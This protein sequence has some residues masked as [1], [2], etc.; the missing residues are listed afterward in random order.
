MT[1]RPRIDHTEQGEVLVVPVRVNVNLKSVT[2]EELTERRK[3]LHMA[4]A[5]NLQEELSYEA[6][7]AIEQFLATA[8][9]RSR[10]VAEVV[11]GQAD[12]DPDGYTV[13]FSKD[14]AAGLPY[15]P[16]ASGTLYFEVEV[17]KPK[18]GVWNRRSMVCLGVAGSC[19]MQ[20]AKPKAGILM[21]TDRASWA[22]FSTSD[23]DEIGTF[24]AHDF[25][26]HRD[27]MPSSWGRQ[28]QPGDVAGVLC[29]LDRGAL[30]ISVNGSF[31]PP[32]GEVFGSGVRP[33]RAVG[34]GLFPVF[35]GEGV[36]LGY[37]SGADPAGRPLR[38]AP[39]EAACGGSGAA[40][41]APDAEGL[42]LDA[43]SLVGR[44][45]H[46]RVAHSALDAARF[47][48]DQRYKELVN[49][50]LDLKVHLLGRQRAAI[51]LC[52]AGAG[53]EQL[54]LCAAAPCEDFGGGGLEDECPYT[55][56]DVF[57]GY[58]AYKPL[59]EIP[60]GLAPALAALVWEAVFAAG[61][62]VLEVKL[63]TEV[64]PSAAVLRERLCLTSARLQYVKYGAAVTG[65]VMASRTLTDLDLRGNEFTSAV[66]ERLTGAAALSAAV[67]VMNG[68]S[69][70]AVEDGEARAGLRRAYAAGC[71]LSTPL[72]QD[73]HFGP[74][75]DLESCVRRVRKGKQAVGLKALGAWL[76]RARWTFVLARVQ[77][78][79]WRELDLK[80]QGMK[81]PGSAALADSLAQLTSLRR[82]DVQ[83]NELAADAVAAVASGL[84]GLTRLR[85]L[86]LRFN[87][88][89]ADGWQSALNGIARCDPPLSAPALAGCARG[90]A[91]A[92]SLCLHAPRR[93]WSES[94]A[95]RRALP[96]HGPRYP[97][98]AGAF[99]LLSGGRET[100]RRPD[101]AS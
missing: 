63:G 84:A 76:D 64:L 78:L 9:R 30:S 4:M 67:V 44:F 31:A 90:G 39:A 68:C 100:P 55:W 28:L 99:F 96:D 23:S 37:N 77:A 88:L 29:D 41:P 13:A 16:C 45:R 74:G 59:V 95:R 56:P 11:T 14:A 70:A 22:V 58:F 35:G 15:A 5:K 57:S 6:A 42:G 27:G 19:Y 82:L 33:G 61:G 80:G 73:L 60:L 40:R 86:D 8:G 69:L 43:A 85:E 3:V 18:D 36:T 12:V 25:D 92:C 97:G 52:Q 10:Q 65:L 48:E 47:N 101:G 17:M 53:K 51:A 38:F 66:T 83:R 75:K 7:A 93:A 1:S 50:A 62:A 21:G 49:E 46:L 71:S 34:C 94:A 81:R 79:D 91:A 54:Q 98:P 24:R 2:V 32:F 20:R 87:G 72:F 26:F 89:G